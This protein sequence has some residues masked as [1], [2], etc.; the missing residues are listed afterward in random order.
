MKKVLFLIN[1][2]ADGGAERVLVDLAN[3]MDKT[4]FDVT[5]QT[6][7]DT[8]QRKQELS[9][10]VSYK[11]II[12]IHNPF[13]RK[14]L[15]AIITRVIPAKFVYRM[16]VKNNYDIEVAFLEGLPTK[17]IAASDTNSKKFAWVHTDLIRY[18]DSFKIYSSHTACKKVYEKFNKIIGVSEDVITQFK[19]KLDWAEDNTIVAYNVNND[20]QIR[21]LSKET[22][23]DLKKKDVVTFISC[24][25]LTVQK[26]FDRLIRIHKRLID[27]KFKCELWIV[28]GGSEYD[29]LNDYITENNLTDSVILFGFQSNP[30][31]YIANAD[32]FVCSSNTEGYSSVVTEA[33]ILQ[34]PVITVK[35]AGAEEPKECLRYNILCE[36]SEEELYEKMKYVL[37]NPGVISEFKAELYKKR[38]YFSMKKQVEKIEKILCE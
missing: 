32:V 38:S 24:G 12:K 1:T 13:I 4:K 16:F 19:T 15:T 6:I 25:R 23:P 5:I 17:I 31:K 33:I 2:L 14:M 7:V 18:S 3:G 22:I 9:G 8:G 29:K 35:V 20:E 28:G 21:E 10:N 26:G 11:T 27:E 34:L 36:N 37:E 30:Y